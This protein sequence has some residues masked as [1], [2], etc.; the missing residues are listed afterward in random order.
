MNFQFM[1][2]QIVFLLVASASSSEKSALKQFENFYFCSVPSA[3]TL[4]EFKEKGGALVVDLREVTED[5]GREEAQVKQLGMKYRR[6]PISKSPPL[7]AKA[8]AAVE[9]AVASAQ[10]EPVLI[11]CASGNRASAWLAIHLVEKEN[12]SLDDALKAA[13][14]IGL[15]SPAME[16]EIRRFLTR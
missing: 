7:S 6:A 14:N 1:V 15:T 4:K 5:D 10:K 3:L 16:K 11:H 8:M 9:V 13:K 12:K 2:F